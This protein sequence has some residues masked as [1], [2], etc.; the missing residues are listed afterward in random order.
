[1]TAHMDFFGRDGVQGEM[2]AYI[3]QQGRINPAFMR[4]ILGRDGHTYFTVYQGGD[5]KKKES[6]KTFR[7]DQ[8]QHLG[9]STYGTL[10]R[11]EWKQLDEA[12][13]QISTIRLGGVQDLIDNNLVYNLG[14][15]MGTTVLE[16]HSISDAMAAQVDMDPDVRSVGDR[17]KYET[18]Y[19]PI[20]VIHSDFDISSRALAASRN[21]GNP[22]DV[23]SV[24]AA[25]RKVNETLEAMLFNTNQTPFGFGGG[26]I[27]SYLDHP[28]RNLY[29]L[30]TSWASDTGANILADVLGMMQMSI[31]AKHY[32]PWMLYIPTAYQKVLS[33]DY[34]S[35]YPKSIRARILEIEGIKGIKVIDTLP[36][37]NV[38]L[39]EM[40]AQTVRL[41]RGMGIQTVEWQV[42][43]SLSPTKYKVLTIQ[44]PQVRADQAGNCGIVHAS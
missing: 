14:N 4:P 19:L 37:N 40:Q 29:S 9:I 41:V 18:H 25:T 22:L 32:G 38:V 34:V 43:S 3:A 42:G 11:D 30:G 15:A 8:V 26:Y 44:V 36:A 2:A 21:L 10:R 5:P 1:M 33:E 35:G 20:P 27:Y 7:R 13:Q 6:Y 16:Y 17:P 39:V 23:D 31:D 28:S 24:Q 12:V